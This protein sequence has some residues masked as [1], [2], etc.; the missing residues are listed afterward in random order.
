MKFTSLALLGAL[1]AGTAATAHADPDRWQ[2]QN[3]R[4]GDYRGYQSNYQ[5]DYG[6][7]NSGV[8]DVIYRAY[9]DVLR[10]EPDAG[11]LATYRQ[12]MIRE[13]WSEQQLRQALLE[14]DEYR[15]K[16]G[17]AYRGYHGYRR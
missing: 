7:R 12:R 15:V 16:F 13:G 6:Y 3:S 10:R 14:S 8:D 1:A 2:W 11:G 17:N 9:R 5:R 4:R